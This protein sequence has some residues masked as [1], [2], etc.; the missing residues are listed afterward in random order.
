M[1]QRQTRPSVAVLAVL[2]VSAAGS[3]RKKTA[4]TAKTAKDAGRPEGPLLIDGHWDIHYKHAAGAH[5]TRFLAALRDEQKIYGVRCTSCSRVLVPP[6][7]FCE[8]CFAETGDWVTVA[9]EGVVETCTI[10]YEAFPG[11]PEP[12]YAVG[13]VRLDGADSAMLAFLGGVPLGDS[14]KALTKI[15]I[16]CRV[17]AKFRK[18]REGR[19]TDIEYFGPA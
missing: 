19:V 5:A 15:G 18:K 16:G 13:L 4:K 10:Q 8:R 2:A 12:P 3:G 7:S 9:S 1:S 14:E 6:R 11:L 17:K